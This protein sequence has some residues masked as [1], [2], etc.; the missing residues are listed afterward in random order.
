MFVKRT[1]NPGAPGCTPALMRI[2]QFAIITAF[3]VVIGVLLLYVTH[4]GRADFSSDDAVLNMLAE[5]IAQQKALFPIGWV[6]NNGDLMV[7]SGALILAPL[8][9]WFSNSFALHA[10]AG[11]LAVALML[12]SFFTFLKSARVPIPIVLLATAVLATGPSRLLAIMLFLQTTYVWLAAG[13]FI[14]VTLIWRRFCARET[15]Q[16]PG[17]AGL[18]SLAVIVFLLSFANPGRALVMLLLP[19]YVFDRALVLH[20]PRSGAGL[21]K[22]AGMVGLNDASVLVGLA[23]PF[24][25]AS[26]S[27]MCLFHLG[28]VETTHNASRL[29][30]DG[31]G[32]LRKHAEVFL[33]GWLPSLG[34]GPEFIA[35]PGSL[36]RWLGHIRVLFA[37]WLTWVALAEV[38]R[39]RQNRNPLRTALVLAWLAALIPTLMLFIVFA[40]L[41]IDSS[42]MR[43]FTLPLLMLLAMAAIRVASAGESWKVFAPAAGILMSSFLI[44]VSSVRFIP[45][46]TNPE[47]RFLQTRSSHAIRLAELLVQERLQW[48]YATWWNAGA[49]TVLSAGASRVSPIYESEQGLVPF[50]TMIHRRWYKP[51]SWT[52]ETFLV[53]SRGEATQEKLSSIGMLLGAANRTINSDEFTIFVYD[54]NIAS[55]F[56]C[57]QSSLM[58]APDESN[59]AR[60]NILSASLARRNPMNADD[61]VSVLI[62]NRGTQVLAG[63]G[64]APIALAFA[65]VR[66]AESDSIT[67]SVEIPLPCAILPGET[68][69]AQIKL[70]EAPSGAGK[71][72][73]ALVQQFPDG[74]RELSE[75]SLEVPFLVGLSPE[76]FGAGF[77][78]SAGED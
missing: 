78:R 37:A 67:S 23:L 24:L 26:I 40:P 22:F 66:G 50:S 72:R 77:D 55:G 41:A 74:L 63:Q 32:S 42:T 47:M 29:Y 12:L 28:I 18:I 56:S 38:M 46:A 27:Y 68:R 60:G 7:P 31:L 53:L 6:S 58:L 70:P 34:G 65:W 44:A 36:E 73:I 2:A 5:A 10:V 21:R 19:L 17:I 1:T 4:F 71:L 57:D 13:F 45:A 25:V 54:W 14:S 59:H 39:L 16:R 61:V 75:A 51:A 69:S 3:V 52:G 11:V 9:A 62:R 15:G 20:L 49:A 33:R 48:G 43:Y 8:L 64:V 76:I 35:T 30:W